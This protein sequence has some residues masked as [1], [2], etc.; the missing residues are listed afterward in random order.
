MTSPE[1]RLYNFVYR[2]HLTEQALDAVGRRNRRLAE[3]FVALLR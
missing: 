2:A 1:S 3:F